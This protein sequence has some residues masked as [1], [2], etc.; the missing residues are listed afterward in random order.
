[1]A[2]TTLALKT[3]LQIYKSN[4]R[5]YVI[6]FPLT[7]ATSPLVGMLISFLNPIARINVAI[8]KTKNYAP[9]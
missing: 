2:V 5:G 3:F 1:M 9:V 4:A 6:G 7:L 8:G